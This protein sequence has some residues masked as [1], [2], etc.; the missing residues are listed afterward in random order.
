[1]RLKVVVNAVWYVICEMLRHGVPDSAIVSTL[2]DKNNKIS[3]HIYDQQGKDPRKYAEKQV[4]EGKAEIQAKKEPL[5]E[6]LDAGDDAQLP[7]PR[8]WLY[9]NI[10]ARKFLSS[11]F[12]DGGI[13]KS[14]L[15]YAQY[16]SLATGKDL[17]GEHIFQRCRVLIISLEDDI[18]ELRRR[19]WALRIRYNIPREELKGWLF[20]WAPKAD[21]GKLMELNKWGN[22]VIGKLRDKLKAL[23]VQHKLDLVGIDPFIKTHSVGENDNTLI[24]KV[25]QVLVNLSHEMNIAPD[26]PH[27][28][29]KSPKNDPEPG[30]ANRGRGASAMKDAARL[31]YTLNVMTKDEAEKFGI[32]DEDRW[33]YVRMDKG[34][35]NIVPP[36][37]QA[38]GSF[39]R[40][41][42]WKCKRDVSSWG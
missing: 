42:H 1:M 9:G 38:N 20:L 2:L 31:V 12:G 39:D 25:V 11:L 28:V 22:L 35:V 15:R 30:D 27:H 6:I 37:R 34:K 10:F 8:E 36:S 7:P 32:K 24:D 18:D 29:S 14:A 40:S 17:A 26:V 41:A 19:I 16:M 4:A 21:E 13:G 23:I 3:D 5:P 33:A